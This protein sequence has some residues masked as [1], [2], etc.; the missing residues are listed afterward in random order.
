LLYFTLGR[1]SSKYAVTNHTEKPFWQSVLTGAL[2][3]GSGCTLGDLIAANMLLVF[4][5]MLFGSHIYGEWAVDFG[6]AFLIGII[7]QYYAIKPM[8]NM[9]RGKILVAALKADTL[10]LTS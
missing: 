7:F 6:L 2:H 9:S 8:G 10:S 3:C 5:V 4:P 1:K